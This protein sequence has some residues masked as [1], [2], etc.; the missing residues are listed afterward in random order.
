MN[1]PKIEGK[2]K[3]YQSDKGF[4]FILVPNSPD[5]FF[6]HSQ[7]RQGVVLDRGDIVQFTRGEGKK[8][9][10]AVDIEL[11]RK[12]SFDQRTQRRSNNRD[13]EQVNEF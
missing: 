10:M 6:H 11:L 8:G 4:G 12:A 9:P 5:L 13:R 2:V 1:S 3:L 7:V